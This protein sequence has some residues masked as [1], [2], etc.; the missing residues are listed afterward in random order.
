MQHAVEIDISIRASKDQ[1][2]R[3]PLN[4]FKHIMFLEIYRYFTPV[5]IA[6][7]GCTM[8]V[9]NIVSKECRP[10]VVATLV[11][12][13]DVVGRVDIEQTNL[14]FLTLPSEEAMRKRQRGQSAP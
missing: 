13:L 14:L 6:S 1:A 12:Y 9:R 5:L 11:G 2:C 4:A 10:C 3:E 7:V 8:M